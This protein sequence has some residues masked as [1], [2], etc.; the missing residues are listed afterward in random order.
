MTILSSAAA[1]WI[2]VSILDLVM[3]TSLISKAVLVILLVFSVVSWA[4]IF[5]KWNV[6]RQ[7]RTS[8]VRFLRAFRKANGLEAV[9]LASEQFRQ[10]P[11]VALFEFGYEEVERQVKA[12][13]T[14][15]NKLALERSL[16]LGTSEELT[17]LERNMN[18]LATTASVSPF[19]GL[20]GTVLGII[21]AFHSIGQAGASSLRAVAPGISD[22]LVATAM[23][24]AAAIPAAVFYNHFGHVIREMGARMDDFSLEFM[25]LAERNFED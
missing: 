10:S 9:A 7:A 13:G 23:G 12:R 14:L 17:K 21:D 1:F 4:V 22:A 16:Q 8:N 15:G 5:S 6:F 20:F 18:W 24:L 3:R 11:L 2:Q 25:N 19:I